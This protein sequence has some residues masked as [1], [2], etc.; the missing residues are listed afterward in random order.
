MQDA[1]RI[2]LLYS[3]SRCLLNVPN[4]LNLLE[5]S[6]TMQAFDS[7]CMS[8][9]YSEVH[10]YNRS[11]HRPRHADMQTHMDEGASLRHIS[12]GRH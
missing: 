12:A 4:L 6:E 10:T 2:V 8:H 11:I 1:L 9:N 3:E 7:Y 5:T